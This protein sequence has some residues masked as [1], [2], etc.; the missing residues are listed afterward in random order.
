MVSKSA[1]AETVVKGVTGAEPS[2]SVS[3]PLDSS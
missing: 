3:S 1:E 2:A